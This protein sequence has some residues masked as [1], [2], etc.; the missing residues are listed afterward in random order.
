MNLQHL[1]YFVELAHTK[2]YS[3]TA[4]V[5]HITQPSLTYAINQLEEELGV[6]LFTKNGRN[7][8][9]TSYGEQFLGYAEGALKT[10]DL[11]VSAIHNKTYAETIIRIGFLRFLGIEYVPKLISSFQEAYPEYNVRFE[12][13]TGNTKLLLQGLNT[14]RFDVV[15]CAPAKRVRKYGTMIGMQRLY[16]IVPKG[17]P[18]S[19]RTSVRLEDTYEYPYVYYVKGTGMRNIIEANHP[20]FPEHIDIKYEII[21][22]RVM[23]GFVASG[24]GIGIVPQMKLLENMPV[25]VIEIVEPSIERDIYMVPTA[26]REMSPALDAFIQYTKK[27]IA[28]QDNSSFFRT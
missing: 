17:H 5:L 23:A 21:E 7:N 27:R 16:L 3:A 24:L 13:E 2:N 20:D 6:S 15:F 12:C 26:T 11:G 10:L 22:E 14:S 9:L 1:K 4:E 25:D 18:L 8:T 19:S 28:D